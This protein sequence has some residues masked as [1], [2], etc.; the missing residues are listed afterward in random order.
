VPQGNVLS[1][2]LLSNQD[3]GSMHVHP[4]FGKCV[5]EGLVF[6]QTYIFDW[7]AKLADAHVQK[8][9]CHIVLPRMLKTYKTQRLDEKSTWLPRAPSSRMCRSGSSSG[10]VTCQGYKRLSSRRKM[11]LSS[12]ESSASFNIRRTCL[13]PLQCRKLAPFSMVNIDALLFSQS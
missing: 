1:S 12:L 2:S 10:H 6:Y 13:L 8:L 5:L 7:G 3:Q 4:I 11:H 9:A